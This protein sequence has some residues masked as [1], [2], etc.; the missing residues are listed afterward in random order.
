MW[1]TL[2]QSV[3]LG[4]KY[5]HI[6]SHSDHCKVSLTHL[7]NTLETNDTLEEEEHRL[8]GANDLQNILKCPEATASKILEDY[9]FLK[10]IPR[11]SISKTVKYLIHT[12]ISNE[13]IANTYPW[14]VTFEPNVLQRKVK[15]VN[16]KLDL[17]ECTIPFLKYSE[18]QL[19]K[20]VNAISS[21]KYLHSE[22][23]LEYLMHKLD[24]NKMELAELTS[25]K[26]IYLLTMDF[27]KLRAAV[28]LLLKY[29]VNPQDIKAD[30]W[31]VRH[32][33]D[34]M[35]ERL[36]IA[37]D[38]G[39]KPIKA[40][41][42]RCTKE[43]FDNSIKLRKEKVDVLGKHRDSMEYLAERLECSCDHIILLFHQYPRLKGVHVSKIKKMLDFLYE[44]NITP[45]QVRQIPTVLCFSLLTLKRRMDDFKEYNYKPINLIALCHTH[46]EYRKFKK[47]LI[48]SQ[49]HRQE[50]LND[51]DLN[52]RVG[53]L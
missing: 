34:L 49:K 53:T 3:V 28:D 7:A 10:Y 35:Q 44:N 22:D 9:R 48:S 2:R 5:V 13:K 19:R 8:T 30:P 52:F 29:K 51:E 16:V 12:G 42:M 33:Y 6:F 50:I 47:W 40:W 41:M 31:V 15:I 39:V 36:K 23:R 21:D 37:H 27:N 1:K 11:K 20:I 32:N 17:D 24:C 18:V 46:K 26:H 4:R 38:S 45:S 43:V 25:G 14:L